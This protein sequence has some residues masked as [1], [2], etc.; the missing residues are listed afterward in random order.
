M[1]ETKIITPKIQLFFLIKRNICIYSLTTKL[2][3]HKFPVN[4]S[5]HL[6]RVSPFPFGKQVPPLLQGFTEQGNM[7]EM[8][9]VPSLVHISFFILFNEVLFMLSLI[10]LPSHKF[11]VNPS[12][13]L[14]RVSPFSLEKQVP[15]LLQGFSV[16]GN[17]SVMKTV[18]PVEHLPFN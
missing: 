10:V 16:Q 2:P 15:P 12:T 9:M 14:Q 18:S 6:Q 3:S 4:P 11:P 17:M 1:S 13:H 7:S 8:K 5:G